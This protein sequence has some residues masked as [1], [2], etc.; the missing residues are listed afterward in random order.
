MADSD[1]LVLWHGG[2]D[3]D[4]P[5]DRMGPQEA[6]KL[7]EYLATQVEHGYTIVTWNGVGFDFDI[8]AEESGMLEECRILTVGHVDMMFHVLCKLGYGVGLDAAARGMGI[9]GKPEGMNGAVAPVLW[10]EG[11]R[12]EVLQYVSQDVRTTLDLVTAC[13]ASGT[14]R[15]IARSG[16]ARKMALPKGWL[17]VDQAEKLPQPNT[18]WM[19]DPWPRT[20]FTGWMG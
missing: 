1:E 9:K 14:M 10:A 3:L 2:T 15:W 11:Q 13:E 16:K 17:A 19:S 18:S 4:H 6:A 8:L 20:K 5:A 7:V 12:E